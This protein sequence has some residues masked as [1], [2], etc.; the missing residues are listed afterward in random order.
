MCTITCFTDAAVDRP[1]D[2]SAVVIPPASRRLTAGVWSELD[3]HLIGM[4]Q[5]L[6]RNIFSLLT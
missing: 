2:S 5:Q 6:A 3:D 1:I 4:S